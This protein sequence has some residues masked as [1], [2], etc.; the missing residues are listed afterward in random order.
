M[1]KLK[2]RKAPLEKITVSSSRPGWSMI[3]SP[4]L[5]LHKDSDTG[6]ICIT[7][8]MKGFSEFNINTADAESLANALLELAGG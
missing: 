4:L 8:M 1:I 6:D 2:R 7:P 3:K 5:L